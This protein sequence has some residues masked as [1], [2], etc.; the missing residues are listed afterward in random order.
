MFSSKS[1]HFEDLQE[2]VHF[3]NDYVV[4]VTTSK[5]FAYPNF[6]DLRMKH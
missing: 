4:A 3:R 5:T 6:F 1:C 2:E